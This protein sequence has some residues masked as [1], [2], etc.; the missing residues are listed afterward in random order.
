MQVYKSNQFGQILHKQTYVYSANKEL[1][2]VTI[3]SVT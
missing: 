2:I 3:K 1:M